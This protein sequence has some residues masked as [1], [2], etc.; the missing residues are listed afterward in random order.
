[1]SIGLPCP[2]CAAGGLPVDLK[3][4]VA[5]IRG[6]TDKQ[7]AVGFGI[8]TPEQV[9]RPIDRSLGACASADGCLEGGCLTLL[10]R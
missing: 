3:E 2:A 4:F 10:F 8:A 5:R 6:V 9:G 1:M 7:L